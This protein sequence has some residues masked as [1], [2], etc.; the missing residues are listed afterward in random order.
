MMTGFKITAVITTRVCFE[1]ISELF[2][3]LLDLMITRSYN[4]IITG[5][6]E[7]KKVNYAHIVMV[8]RIR[9]FLLSKMAK[10]V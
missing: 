2:R 7:I 10:N 5:S 4:E 3:V 1:Y 9:V 6:Y 8:P